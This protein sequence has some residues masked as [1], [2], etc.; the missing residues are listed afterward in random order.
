MRLSLPLNTLP[1]GVYVFS[2]KPLADSPDFPPDL[3]ASPYILDETAERIVVLQLLTWNH[4]AFLSTRHLFRLFESTPDAVLADPIPWNSWGTDGTFWMSAPELQCGYTSVFGSKFCAIS[5]YRQ[6]FHTDENGTVIKDEMDTTRCENGMNMRVLV[7][8]F[9]PRPIIRDRTRK[10][11]TAEERAS[12]DGRGGGDTKQGGGSEGEVGEGR[13]GASAGEAHADEERAL[14]RRGRIEVHSGITG[15][16]FGM[17]GGGEIGEWA[18]FSPHLDGMVV[19]RLPFRAFQREDTQGYLDWIVGI[20]HL[21]GISV[22]LF[23][24]PFFFFSWPWAGRMGWLMMFGFREN[25][26]TPTT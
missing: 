10:R 21:V 7:M 25:R 24:F 14:R 16:R 17:G 9:N 1:D 3:C 23:F 15:T 22:R 11:R 26:G 13:G 5:G 19:T 20:D 6:L 4:Y 18:C 8:D 12:E 2:D